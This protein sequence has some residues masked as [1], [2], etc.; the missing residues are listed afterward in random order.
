MIP[1]FLRPLA[2]SLSRALLLDHPK[3]AHPVLRPIGFRPCADLTL[4]FP[5]PVVSASLL[6]LLFARP[7]VLLPFAI[8]DDVEIAL[9]EKRKM[10]IGQR[11]IAG[12]AEPNTSRKNGRSG[13]TRE[14]DTRIGGVLFWLAIDIRIGGSCLVIFG[15]FGGSFSSLYEEG[16]SLVLRDIRSIRASEKEGSFFHF[17]PSPPL[18][19]RSF[20]AQ[21]TATSLPIL[22]RVCVGRSCR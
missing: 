2:S 1:Y 15:V 7:P 4:I 5:S 8:H 20:G 22:L 6:P 11:T 17:P 12:P 9:V 10:M 21:R 13:R 16:G 14:A 3:R 18:R 19:A